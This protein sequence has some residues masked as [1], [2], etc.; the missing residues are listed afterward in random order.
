[1]RLSTL[2]LTGAVI[3]GTF[4]GLSGCA[5]SQETKDAQGTRLS[6]QHEMLQAIDN[7]KRYPYG[8]MDAGH[9]G[10]VTVGFDYTDGGKADN[11]EIVESS[12][13]TYLDH[14]AIMAVYFAK[15]PRKPP[16]LKSITR[17]IVKVNFKMGGH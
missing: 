11:F 12:G 8:A 13:D 15:L 14:A 17:F 16:E 2:F 4:L 9:H 5:E 10:T 1:M 7:E 3:T 6:F